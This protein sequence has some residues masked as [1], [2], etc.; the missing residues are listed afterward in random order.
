[1]TIEKTSER[2]HVYRTEFLSMGF[3]PGRGRTFFSPAIFNKHTIP[4]GFV[5]N[6][7]GSLLTSERSYV[8]RNK[9]SGETFDPGRG[10][11]FTSLRIFYKHI[12]PPG[13]ILKPINL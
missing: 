5:S 7:A 4:P 13:L 8:Y 11:T 3:D 9:H 2:S 12:I 10:R 6:Q 1:M